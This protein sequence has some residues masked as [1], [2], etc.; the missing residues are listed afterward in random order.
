MKIIVSSGGLG[1]QMFFYALYEYF[2][3]NEKC[4]LDISLYDINNCHNGYEIEKIFPLKIEHIKIYAFKNIFLRI[5]LKVTKLFLKNI[6]IIYEEKRDKSALENLNDIKKGRYLFLTGFWGSEKYFVNIKEKLQTLY[7]FPEL[8]EE[9]N[10]EIAKKI[11]N[12]ESVSVHIRRGDY[13]LPENRVYSELID[14]SYY[15][16][17]IKIIKESVKKPVFFIFSN[18]IEWCKENLKLEEEIYY[19]DW[20]KGENSYRDMQLMSMCKHN[21]IPH[22]TFSWWGAW[23]NQNPNKIVIAPETWFNPKY[24]EKNINTEDLVPNEWIKIKN[25]KGKK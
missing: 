23:L 21:I 1:N 16:K 22:S 25:Y 3:E 15:E 19:I 9:K 7:T 8:N 13:L 6:K 17:A 10:L 20:N 2:K 12:K 5:L 18:D 11:K 24:L 14:F 4:Y